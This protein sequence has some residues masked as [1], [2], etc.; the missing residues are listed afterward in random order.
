MQSIFKHKLCTDYSGCADTMRRSWSIESLQLWLAGD[1]EL[2]AVMQSTTRC[3]AKLHRRSAGARGIV[4]VVSSSASVCAGSGTLAAGQQSDHLVMAAA[5][6]GWEA[7]RAEVRSS[8]ISSLPL[9]WHSPSSL[10]MWPSQA[11]DAPWIC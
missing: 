9:W 6:A 8:N 10:C 1:S 2:A 7:A 5:L 4:C 11:R 3:S